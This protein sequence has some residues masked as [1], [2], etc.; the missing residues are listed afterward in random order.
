MLYINTPGLA[1]SAISYDRLV[2]LAIESGIAPKRAYIYLAGLGVR[3]ELTKIMQEHDYNKPIKMAIYG[4]VPSF[5]TSA[6]IC[7]KCHKLSIDFA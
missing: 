1:K 7:Q 4:A 6:D 5:V 3:G 2:E